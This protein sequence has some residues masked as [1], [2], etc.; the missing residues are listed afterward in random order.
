VFYYCTVLALNSAEIG[1]V[2]QPQMYYVI[3]NM[4]G[5]GK[6]WIAILLVPFLCVMPD[7]MINMMYGLFWPT[8]TEI[9]MK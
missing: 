1:S 9:I 8:P 5:N 2:F 3:Y 6:A 7:I 4:L